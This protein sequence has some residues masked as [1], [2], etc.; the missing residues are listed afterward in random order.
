VPQILGYDGADYIDPSQETDLL[1][2]GKRFSILETQVIAGGKY[3][4]RAPQSP[5]LSKMDIISRDVMRVLLPPG[6][7][8]TVVRDGKK[9]VE[10][11]VST[12]NGVSNRFPIP[13]GPPSSPESTPEPL[14]AEPAFTLM[15][16]LLRLAANVTPETPA[17]GAGTPSGTGATTIQTTPISQGGQ[18]G[19][20]QPTSPSGGGQGGQ[21]GGAPKL[22]AKAA[23]V[24][25][26]T[27]IRIMAKAAPAKPT[28]TITADFRFPVQSSPDTVISVIVEGIPYQSSERAY[29]LDDSLLDDVFVKDLITKLDDFGKLTGQNA[30]HDLT[31]K[32]ILVTVDGS[33]SSAKATTNQLRVNIELYVQ[34]KPAPT[35]APAPAKPASMSA[36]ATDGTNRSVSATIS[37]GPANASATPPGQT[38]SSPSDNTGATT[39]TSDVMN[40]SAPKT[41]MRPP[42]TGQFSTSSDTVEPAQALSSTNPLPDQAASMRKDPVVTRTAQA[43]A[44]ALPAPPRSASAPGLSLPS[45]P[46]NLATSDIPPGNSSDAAPPRGRVR[47]SKLNPSATSSA[48]YAASSSYAGLRDQSSSPQSRNTKPARR[49]ILSRML[50]KD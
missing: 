20:G 42:S 26:G 7:Q 10:V 38:P 37:G 36:T 12:P 43:S 15:D 19:Q 50:G 9:Y 30:L 49:S 28:Q 2:F 1:I 5:E 3:L 21:G 29:V 16:D 34:K 24:A 6:V 14:N 35:K 13:Y 31:T 22:S 47:S 32:T 27:R 18:G 41:S 25:K 11:V 4:T 17:Q 46:S 45:A 48:P 23:K 44:V 39:P 40:Q 8:P 33:D